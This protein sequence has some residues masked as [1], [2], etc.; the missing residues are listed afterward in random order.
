MSNGANDGMAQVV[1]TLFQVIFSALFPL[2]A[3]SLCAV[4]Y[5]LAH[6]F[7]LPQFALWAALAGWIVAYARIHLWAM[8]A[9][10]A[11]VIAAV[12][13]ALIGFREY[14]ARTSGVIGMWVSAAIYAGGTVW[15][16]SVWPPSVYPVIQGYV[17]AFLL[18][19][20]WGGAFEAAIGTAKIIAQNRPQPGPE[21]VMAQ[22]AH[23][24]AQ[25]A[26]EDEAISLLGSKK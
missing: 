19:V 16:A 14:A 17:F 1:V 21:V 24:D 9:L 4:S 10:I 6:G 2:I 15:L 12:P 11:F 26:G 7:H 8:L 20:S 22:K 25:V 3:I 5:I 13:L 23:G 18:F